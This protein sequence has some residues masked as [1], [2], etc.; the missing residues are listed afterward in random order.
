MARPLWEVVMELGLVD[1]LCVSQGLR[2]LQD[3]DVVAVL[4]LL[5]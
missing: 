4:L 3:Q 5:S 1:L 2:N